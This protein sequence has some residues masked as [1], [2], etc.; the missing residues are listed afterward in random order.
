MQHVDALIALVG[1]LVVA[2]I[3]FYQWRRQYSNPN[4]AVNSAARREAWA[5]LWERLERINLDLR[6]DEEKNP[7]L[8]DQIREVNEFFMAH[9]LYFDD[10]D[11]PLIVAYIVALNTL[12]QQV[13]TADDANVPHAFSQTIINVAARDSRIVAAQDEVQRLRSKIKSKAQRNAADM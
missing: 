9:S 6:S 4:R 1:T 5:G 13:Y 3:G 12:R 2:L 10:R 11:Q 8:F 7:S